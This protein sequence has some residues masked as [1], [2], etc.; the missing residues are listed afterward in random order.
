MNSIVNS[1]S[2]SL[3]RL[4]IMWTALLL[5]PFLLF[6]ILIIG[7]APKTPTVP[8]TDPALVN[9]LHYLTIG[10]AG[11]LLPVGYYIR[12]QTYKKHWVM[13]AVTPQGYVKAN[14]ILF[15]ICKGIALFTIIVTYL[16]G[17]L[18]PYI[19]PAVVASMTHIINWPTGGP[20]ES[21]EMDLRGR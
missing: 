20:M 1:K 18:M 15:A 21:A 8:S 7:M 14:I 19:L 6:G 9:L 17:V 12:L 5:G 16:A 3:T 13:N 4:R 2:I 10:M 11:L